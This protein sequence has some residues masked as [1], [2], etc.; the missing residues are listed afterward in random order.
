MASRSR[1]SREVHVRSLWGTGGEIPPVYP[2]N[3]EV[4]RRS[5]KWKNHEGESTNAEFRG[6]LPC[7]SD[8][9]EP[10]PWSEEDRSFGHDSHLV[11][12]QQEEPTDRGEGRQLFMN[13]KSRVSREAQARICERLGVRYPG[14]LGRQLT[15]DVL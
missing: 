10:C 15:L 14:R 7:I 8:E 6:G 11:N 2:A 12:W 5:H 1:M 4:K 13:D 9:A 3:F